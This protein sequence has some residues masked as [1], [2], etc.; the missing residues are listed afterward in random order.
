MV[1]AAADMPANA[2]FRYD[3]VDIT[4]Q[5][6]AERA[7]LVYNEIV[8]AYKA[9]DRKMFRHSTQRFLRLLLQQDRLLS[10]IPDF[11]VG[12]WIKQARSI[13][14]NAAEADHY[15]W[16]AR[17][18]ITVWGNRQAAEQGGLREYAH[19]EWSGARLLLSAL[20][21][22]LRRTRRHVR[23]QA[24]ATVRLLCHRR[25]MD[26]TPQPVSERGAGRRCGV[27][28]RGY[29]SVGRSRVRKR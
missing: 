19:K 21:H 13:A 5:A 3:L 16:N 27:R 17:T 23:L 8:A 12:R 1:E 29:G 15:E 7:R 28:S 9:H 25:S 10:S 26:T 2:N 11:M 20:A 18:Q 4:R 14:T 6:V 22:V 24:D